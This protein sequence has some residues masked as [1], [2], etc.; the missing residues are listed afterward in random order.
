MSL[1]SHGFHFNGLVYRGHNPLWQ[2]APESGDGAALNGGRWNRVGQPALYTS[3]RFETAWLEAQQGMPFK[4]QPL[5]LCTY[6]VDCGPLLDL[7]DRDV[8]AL[9]HPDADS[10]MHE[11]WLAKRLARQS[12]LAWEI[13]D[14]LIR[15]G[16]VGIRVPSQATGAGAR[17]VN[18]VFWKWSRSRP[19]KVRVID[20]EGRLSR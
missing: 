10:W 6:E 11:A 16:I 17:D 14:E 1:R 8:C 5:T 7:C 12:V 2:H 18:L 3:A 19:T 15:Q 20:D 4:T 9:V 13:A